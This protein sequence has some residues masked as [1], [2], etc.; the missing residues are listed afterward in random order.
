MQVCSFKG[1]VKPPTVFFIKFLLTWVVS[2]PEFTGFP[3][4]NKF[5]FNRNHKII[6]IENMFFCK[7]LK[8]HDHPC[9]YLM[10]KYMLSLLLENNS[11]QSQTFSDPNAKIYNFL[12]LQNIKISRTLK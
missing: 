11:L 12:F 1:D 10:S 8:S 4:K 7:I 6:H 2:V 9:S 3:Q 5:I